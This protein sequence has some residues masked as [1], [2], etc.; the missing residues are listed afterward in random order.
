MRL[1]KR[2]VIKIP[3]LERPKYLTWDTSLKIIAVIRFTKEEMLK[4]RKP[5]KCLSKMS[6]MLEVLSI[7]HLQPVFLERLE[8]DDVSCFKKLYH[9]GFLITLLNIRYIRL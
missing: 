6:E 9:L 5:G 1:L 7:D 2:K 3:N 8:P 4:L